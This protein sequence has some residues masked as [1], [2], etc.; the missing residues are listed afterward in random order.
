ML[1]RLRVRAERTRA[2][3]FFVPALFVG[4]AIAVAGAM[5]QVDV[6]LS[7]RSAQLPT[8]LQTTP[9]SAR[10][11]L[12]T[13]ASATITVA[14]VVFAITLVSIQLAASQF[15]P[16]VIPG[17]LRDSRQQRVMGLAVGTF[18]YC[19]VVLRAV[20]G[21][22]EPDLLFVPHV[23]SALSLVLAIVTIIALVAF[24]DRSARTMQVGHII[25]H[26]T[27]ETT[28]RVRDLYPTRRGRHRPL[29]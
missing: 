20:R 13:V 6:S 3:L 9:D 5:L 14:G 10:N 7:D 16:R 24:L 8:F 22:S 1:D 19:L 25:H 27:D 26:L 17:F 4:V 21:S 29:R 2:S 23:S 18:T 28:A 12:S 15:S 11:L